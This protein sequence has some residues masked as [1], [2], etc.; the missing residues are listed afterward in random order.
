MSTPTSLEFLHKAQKKAQKYL[1]GVGGRL[2]SELL[3]FETSQVCSEAIFGHYHLSTALVF[4]SSNVCMQ[5]S[6]TNDGKLGKQTTT[7]AGGCGHAPWSEAVMIDLNSQ[8]FTL[9][10]PDT[11]VFHYSQLST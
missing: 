2:P 8:M 7:L 5:Y 1:V 4:S 10:Y 3:T 6:S 11:H 9:F